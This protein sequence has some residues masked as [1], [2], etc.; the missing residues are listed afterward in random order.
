MID[1]QHD[2]RTERDEYRKA[3]ADANAQ[4]TASHAEIVYLSQQLAALARDIMTRE[5]VDRNPTST[6]W[7]A[8]DRLMAFAQDWYAANEPEKD[9]N[10]GLPRL[11]R[12]ND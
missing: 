2:L 9:G 6:V 3:L 11:G 4:L 7:A 5:M 8:C 10:N 12:A 1:P